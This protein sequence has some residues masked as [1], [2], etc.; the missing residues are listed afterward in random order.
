MQRRPRGKIRM[1]ESVRLAAPIMRVV[2]RLLSRCDYGGKLLMNTNEEMN[3]FLSND[4]FNALKELFVGAVTWEAHPEHKDHNHIRL[5][6]MSTS[7]LQA[8]ALYEFFYKPKNY[9]PSKNIPTD[10][11]NAYAHHFVCSWNPS[12]ACLWSPQDVASLYSNFMADGT[13]VQKREFHLVYCRSEKHGGTEGDE[14]THLKNRV[15]DFA[16]D[17]LRLTKEFVDKVKPEFRD[18]AQSALDRSLVEAQNL[19]NEYNIPNPLS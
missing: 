1:L 9:D 17:L 13:S 5:L 14:L 2:R 16:V 7:F 3:K 19:A 10:G 18:S 12:D 8:R 11:G 6:G 4:F 15:R